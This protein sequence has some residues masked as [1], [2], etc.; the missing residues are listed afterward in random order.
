MLNLLT[1]RSVNRLNHPLAAP[2]SP[3]APPP[4][5]SVVRLAL[6]ASRAPSLATAMAAVS[7]MRALRLA[8]LAVR[9]DTPAWRCTFSMDSFTCSANLPFSP[10]L[11]KP[12]AGKFLAAVA[13]GAPA[14]VS[15]VCS[16]SCS[17]LT[18][19][20]RS[21]RNREWCCARSSRSLW[22]CRAERSWLGVLSLV[23][24]GAPALSRSGP[25]P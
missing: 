21:S 8:V 1:L 17:I 12:F 19:Y 4:P 5:M 13:A 3:R 7:T 20:V 9:A 22:L 2:P 15:T 16:M 14:S 18:A 25:W 24:R 10:F 23:V 6:G 11:M